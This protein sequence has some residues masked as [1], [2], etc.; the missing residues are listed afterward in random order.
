MSASIPSL[1][2]V[3][4]RIALI[5]GG[6]SGLGLMIAKGLVTNGCKVYITAL[7]SDPIDEV[8]SELNKL[9]KESGN[10]GSAI[11]YIFSHI[12]LFALFQHILPLHASCFPHPPISTQR[13]HHEIN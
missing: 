13:P 12:I 1:F 3:A 10:G 5:T 4:G 9:G 8:V 2:S 11:G 7:S 6:S